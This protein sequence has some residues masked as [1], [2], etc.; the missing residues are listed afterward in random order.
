M[1]L[2]LR[3][4]LFDMFTAIQ[5]LYVLERLGPLMELALQELRGERVEKRYPSYAMFF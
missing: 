1:T 4:E 3:L 5:N 2:A